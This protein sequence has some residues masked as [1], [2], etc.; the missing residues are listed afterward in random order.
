VKDY[1]SQ[2]HERNLRANFWPDDAWKQPVQAVQPSG[3]TNM[4]RFPLASHFQPD[5]PNS[6]RDFGPH[7]G[8]LQTVV[9]DRRRAEFCSCDE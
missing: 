3:P 4:T 8:D 9:F 2:I 5:R 6:A 7:V 1:G